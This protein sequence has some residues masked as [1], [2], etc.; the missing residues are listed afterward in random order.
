MFWIFFLLAHNCPTDGHAT[1]STAGRNATATRC[2]CVLGR[3]YLCSSSASSSVVSSRLD[4][5]TTKNRCGFFLSFFLFPFYLFICLKRRKKM[6]FFLIL[7]NWSVIY[8][9]VYPVRPVDFRLNS[10]LSQFNWLIVDSSQRK[11]RL[12]LPINSIKLG[13]DNLSQRLFFH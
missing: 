7:F 8:F 3:F 6:F 11:F 9:L 12:Q 5:T 4:E 13:I 2:S 10:L 1:E